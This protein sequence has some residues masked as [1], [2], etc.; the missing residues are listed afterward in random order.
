VRLASHIAQRSLGVNRL[1]QRLRDL[2][3]TLRIDV[4]VDKRGTGVS[5][6]SH[7]LRDIGLAGGEAG[8]S[9]SMLPGLQGTS[10]AR[11]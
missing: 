6:A 2:A 10:A 8:T 5:H 11:E 3:L 4:L 9:F 1:R 7:Q